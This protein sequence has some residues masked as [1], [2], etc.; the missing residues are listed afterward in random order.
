MAKGKSRDR[1]KELYWRRIVRKQASSG[2]T[3]QAWCRQHGVQE[4]AF[5]VWR[6][7]LARRDAEEVRPAFVPVHVTDEVPPRGEGRVEIV[8]VDGRRVRIRGQV[9]RQSLA[10]VLAVLESVG[11]GRP[12]FDPVLGP[13]ARTR[14]EAQAWRE[15]AAC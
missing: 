5:Y 4:H 10:D 6:R 15:V 8:L 3:V 13:E 12:A 14:R 9:D 1:G 11:E 2:L 7:E